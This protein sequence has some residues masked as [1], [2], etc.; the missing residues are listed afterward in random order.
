MQLRAVDDVSI[1]VKAGDCF[2]LLGSNGAGKT[3]AFR[4][5][6]HQVRPTSGDI[7]LAGHSVTLDPGH[8][9]TVSGYCPQ[10]GGLSDSLTGREL[11]TFYARLRGMTESS[12]PGEVAQL[13]QRLSLCESADLACGFYSGTV[14][15]VSKL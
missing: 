8:A 7:W 5:L 11:L 10:F 4:M 13:L 6:T 1:M 9:R 3:T 15:L 14:I 12:I 2:G